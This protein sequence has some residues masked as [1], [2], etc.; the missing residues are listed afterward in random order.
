MELRKILGQAIPAIDTGAYMYTVPTLRGAV[1]STITVCN[2][3]TSASVFSIHI[4]N[5]SDGAAVAKNTLFDSV[6]LAGN[7]TITITIGIT[8]SNL[9]QVYF[10]NN[11]GFLAIS[12]YGVEFDQENVYVP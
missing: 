6:A 11:T 9:D 5:A 7:D 8:L 3:D 10:I 4:V 2:T 1:I 12:V